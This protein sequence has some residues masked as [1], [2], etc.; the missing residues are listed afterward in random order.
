MELKTA[1]QN[2][3]QYKTSQNILS[4]ELSADDLNN[5]FITACDQKKSRLFRVNVF[6]IKGFNSKRFFLLHYRNS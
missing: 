1:K 2:D 5:Y 6:M 4:G 3:V